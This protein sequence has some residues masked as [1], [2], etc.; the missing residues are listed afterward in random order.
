MNETILLVEDEPVQRRLMAGMLARK[1]HYDTLTASN[2]KEAIAR[3]QSSNVGSI[4]AVLLDLHMP[5]MNGLETLKTIRTLRPDLPVLILTASDDI[6]NAVHAIK[7]GACDFITKPAKPERLR[8]AIQNAIRLSTLAHELSRLKRERN[9]SLAFVELVGHQ[10]GLSG[11]IAYGRKAAA[12]DVPVLLLGESGSGKELFARTI[13]GESRRASGPFITLNCSTLAHHIESLLFGDGRSAG[14]GGTLRDL[15]KI[16]AAEGGTLFL[17]DVDALPIEA[18]VRLL[19]V[20]QQKEVEPLGGGRAVRVNLRII[21]A[22]ERDLTREIQSGRFREDLYFR[23]NVLPITMPAL[24]ER[25]QDIVPLAEY[26]ME[27]VSISDRLP[28]KPLTS[29]AKHALRHHRWPGNV[30]ELEGMMH[31]ALVLS[32]EDHIDRTVIDRVLANATTATPTQ[33]ATTDALSITL[34]HADGAFKTIAEIE[35]EAMRTV[36]NYCQQNISRAAD[37]LGMAKSTFYRKLKDV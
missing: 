13:H 32:D 29:D 34:R 33:I 27:R 2:G 8:I 6:E 36:L 21:C 19:R 25:P 16:R 5:G 12:S 14:A 9:N 1:L 30:R 37:R 22:T 3:I 20:L 31:R 7:E 11:A 17:D 15:G 28:L 23:L 18:Q 35:V 24:R 26:F 4:N 10:D